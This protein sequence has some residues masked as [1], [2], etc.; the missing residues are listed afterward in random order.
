M[1]TLI[2]DLLGL[3]L[4]GFLG[5]FGG[6]VSFFVTSTES[7]TKFKAMGLVSKVL[8]AFFVAVV[9][10]PFIEYKSQAKAVLLMGSGFFAYPILT[11][12]ERRVLG[13]IDR[14]FPGGLN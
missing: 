2:A 12:I 3:A 10:A 9:I 11:L 4:P 14:V 13:V 1:E 7:P 5:A 8:A 6:L